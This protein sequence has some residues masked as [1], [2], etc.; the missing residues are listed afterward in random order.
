MYDKKYLGLRLIKRI[1]FIG[2]F[3]IENIAIFV[4]LKDLFFN[5]NFVVNQTVT[6]RNVSHA[7]T[8]I[9]MYRFTP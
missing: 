9:G 8:L 6:V 5:K 7:K 3:F 1:F 4:H 2:T